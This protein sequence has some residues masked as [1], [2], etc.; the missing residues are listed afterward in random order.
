VRLVPFLA[1]AALLASSSPGEAAEVV[2]SNDSTAAGIPSTVANLFVVGESTA[3]WLT[4]SCTGDIVAMQVYWASQF[5]GQPPQ[6][7]QALTL[8]AAGIFPT[9]GATLASIP[10]P[11]FADGVVNEFRFLDPPVNSVPLQVPI[12]SGQGFVVSTQF[13]NQSAGNPFASS[14]TYDQDSCQAGANAV[15]VIPGGWNDACPLGVTGDWV[16]RAVIDC[17]QPAVPALDTPGYLA[18]LLSLSAAGIGGLAVARR[19]SRR[20]GEPGE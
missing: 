9:P 4:A 5:G 17:A 10:G 2:E 20:R 12:V 13:A 8:F 3:A 16:I 15:D 19:A 11:T 6:L 1:L 14:V 18:L 7:E